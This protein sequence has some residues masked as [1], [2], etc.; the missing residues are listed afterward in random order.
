MCSAVQC[1][2]AVQC[3]AVQCSAV[4]CSGAVSREHYSSV[5]AQSAKTCLFICLNNL[6]QYTTLL[7]YSYT[8]VL[9]YYSI[10]LVQH[11]C[12]SVLLYFSTPV[13]LYS[14]TPPRHYCTSS[15][16]SS[17]HTDKTFSSIWKKIEQVLCTAYCW[18]QTDH[19]IGMFM[20]C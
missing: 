11:S 18:S 8:P 2:V 16:T 14:L 20:L 9:L 1:S 12:I 5:L 6:S 3:S 15:I 10:P 7:Q 17:V 4:Q 19:N 13:L